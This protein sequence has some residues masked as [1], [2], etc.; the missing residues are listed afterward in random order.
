MLPDGMITIGK[1][2][3]QDCHNL[4]K[5]SIPKGTV[6]IPQELFS[7]CRYLEELTVPNSVIYVGDAA[8]PS[9]NQITI[10]GNKNIRF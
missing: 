3:F 10:H 9:G 6:E 2:A 7:G 1:G 4:R 8:I 5:A